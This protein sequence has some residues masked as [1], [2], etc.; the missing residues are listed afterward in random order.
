LTVVLAWATG[1]SCAAV[2]GVGTCGG[3]GVFALVIILAIDVAIATALLRLC[4]VIDPATTA[5]LGVGLVAVLAMLFFLG[6]TQ[7][8]AMV[9]VIPTL[10]AT[11]FTFAWWLTKAIAQRVDE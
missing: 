7:S 6:Q 10:M 8:F 11:T 9:Y 1:E 3:Y 4:R 2:R 5:L